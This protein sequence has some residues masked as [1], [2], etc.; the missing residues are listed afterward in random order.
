MY[1]TPSSLKEGLAHLVTIMLDDGL[2]APVLPLAIINEEI[3]VVF[4]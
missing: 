3:E 4:P 2:G 1:Y